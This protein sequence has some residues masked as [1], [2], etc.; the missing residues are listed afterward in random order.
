M[1]MS[2]SKTVLSEV[3]LNYSEVH[4]VLLKGEVYED[5]PQIG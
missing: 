1:E 4:D 3:F 5:C 2:R